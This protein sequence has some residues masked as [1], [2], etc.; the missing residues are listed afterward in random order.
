M[1][2]QF[3]GTDGNVFVSMDGVAPGFDAQHTDF[4]ATGRPVTIDITAAVGGDWAKLPKWLD[5]HGTLG[6]AP[7]TGFNWQTTQINVHAAEIYIEA[8]RV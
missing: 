2:R 3:P 4:D 6:Y 7:F 8:H 5:I 1:H